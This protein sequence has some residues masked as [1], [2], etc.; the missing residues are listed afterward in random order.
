M[1][2]PL[3]HDIEHAK[4]QPK[5]FPKYR[6]VIGG[7]VVVSLMAVG[8]TIGHTV[9][10]SGHAAKADVGSGPAPTISASCH[11]L[12]SPGAVPAFCDSFDTPAGTGNRSGDLNGTVWGVS[13]RGQEASSQGMWHEW[14]TTQLDLCGTTISVTTPNDVRICN[15]HLAEALN[16]GGGCCD[17]GAAALFAYPKQPFDI[18]GRTG[19]VVFDVSNDTQG[20]H[21]AW[22][23]F[24]YTDQPT[25]VPFGGFPINSLNPRN[26]LGIKFFGHCTASG[27]KAGWNIGSIVVSTNYNA[28]DTFVNGNTGI[29]LNNTGCVS[30]ASAAGDSSQGAPANTLNHVELRISSQHIDVYATDAF[31]VGTTALPP[32]VHVASISLAN[33]LPLTR[34]LTWLGDGH[35]NAC[36]AP[37]TQCV[38]TFY[39]DNFGFDGP[40][41]PQD[42][43][44]D[45]LDAQSPRGPDGGVD[46]GWNYNPS[47]GSVPTLTTAP[48]DSTSLG[49]ATGALLTFNLYSESAFSS[50]SAQV[51]GNTVSSALPFSEPSERTF[52]IPVPLSDIKTGPNSISFLN[53]N[54]HQ[55]TIYNVDIILVG[56]GGLPAGGGTS[57]GGGGGASPTATA[58][59]PGPGPQPPVSTQLHD[60]P[61]MVTINGTTVHGTCSGTFVPA[62]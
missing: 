2:R 62:G 3:Y 20:G 26:G 8:A 17:G 14:Y 31:P 54:I 49:K 50:I 59:P 29:N 4:Q 53:S 36:K 48:V 39:W 19:T 28:L 60:V 35:Y 18:A 38:H 33:P 47:T 58:A 9:W 30:M 6:F 23:E 16:D 55:V 52:A 22:P 15:G 13:R 61:C 27:G 45:V 44:F 41:L 32:L 5:P 43:A 57:G 34:G 12:S 40:I 42:R 56:G 10:N 11:Y 24:W 7:L 25:P 37:G 21:A 1:R 46:G 51:N